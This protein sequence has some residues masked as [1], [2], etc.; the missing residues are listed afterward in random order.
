MSV[1]L[2][3]PTRNQHDILDRALRSIADA[4]RTHPS[5]EF[6]DGA[7][8]LDI[9]V[10]DNQSDDATSQ[11]YLAEL[12]ACAKSFGLSGVRVLPYH[13]P[14]NYADINNRAAQQANSDVL[15][16][17]NN[18]VEVL[19]ADWLIT[20]QAEALKPTQG[21]VGPLLYFPNQTVQ[22]AGVVMG[23]GTVA[24]HAY[25][26][27]HQASVKGHP[28]FQQSRAVTAVTGA[29]LAIKRTTFM[30]VGQFDTEL[31]VAFNDIDLCLKVQQAGYQNVFLPHIELLHHESLSRGKG[32]KNGPAKQ[33]HKREIQRMRKRWGQG[34]EAD[35]HWVVSNGD[36]P[37]DSHNADKAYRTTRRRRFLKS[38][39]EDYLHKDLLEQ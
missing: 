15:C 20:L 36:N 3:I 37:K 11:A 2:V 29:C 23:M 17:L 28:Y 10:V 24:G 33:R 6:A 18:D 39:T 30:E 1:S 32:I 14:F 5:A 31:A 9:V 8:A 26:G 22:H 19:S 25:V 13:Q 21:C 34:V 27:L 16:F 35:P 4:E 38:I 12:P 7:S